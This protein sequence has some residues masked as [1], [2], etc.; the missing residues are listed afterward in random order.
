MIGFDP[1]V[2][3]GEVCARAV[4][5]DIRALRM[6]SGDSRAAPMAVIVGGRAP[7]LAGNFLQAVQQ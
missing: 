2:G 7:T 5:V 1:D 3:T 6:T 4:V